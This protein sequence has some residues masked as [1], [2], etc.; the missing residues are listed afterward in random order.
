MKLERFIYPVGQ[1]GFAVERIGNYTVVYDCG[2]ISSL[3]MVEHCIDHL[4]QEVKCVDVLFISHFDKDHVNSIKYLLGR[5]TVYRAV[6]S[7]IPNN[8]KT[9]FGVYTDGGYTRIR[10]LLDDRRVEVD[11]VGD[12]GASKSYG[13]KDIWEWIAKSM[14]TQEELYDVSS[15]LEYLNV[16]M[17]RL[18]E[19]PDYIEAYKGVINHAFKRIFGNSGPNAKG[20]I[21]LSQRCGH[22]VTNKTV[23]YEGCELCR[24][25]PSRLAYKESSCLY[26]GDADLKNRSNKKMVKDLLDKCSTESPL[27]LMQI[28]HHGSKYNVGTRFENDYVS[29]LYF[30]NDRNTKRIEKNKSF[31]S[32]LTNNQKLLVSGSD[33]HNIIVTKTEII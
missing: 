11:E 12:D 15:Y 30:V 17:I 28:P 13:S 32:S 25:K 6:I 33:C 4:A 27:L 19:D 20:L 5:L 8:L 22:T 2:S 26:V 1:G 29:H 14:M 31:Y 9:A 10:A 18:S 24:N 7:L 21:V 16:D 23:V 3:G